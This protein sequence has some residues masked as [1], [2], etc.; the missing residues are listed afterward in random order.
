M[1]EKVDVV[2]VGAGFAGLG[3][4]YHLAASGL[5][6]L[7]VERG[8]YP[9]SKNVTGGRLYL[10]PV[11]PYFPDLFAEDGL[12]DI[13]FECLVVKERLTM[14]S[15]S[16]ATSIE[17]QPA[18]FGA[19]PAHSVTLLRG[20][21]DRWLGDVVAE[22]GA[23]VVPGYKVDDLVWED[24]RVVG[25]ISAGAEV[26]ADVVVAA[27]GAL[28]FIAERAGLRGRHDPRHFAVGIKEVIELPAERIRDRF[29]LAPGQ[30]ASQLFFG[31]L[32]LGMT[33]GGFLY[34]NRESLSLGLV[35]GMAAMEKKGGEFKAHEMM[36]SFK[37]RPEIAPLIAGGNVIEYSAHAVPEDSQRA[38]PRLVHNGLIV[39][40]DAAGLGLNMGLTVRGM[41]L[42][43]ASGA[44]AAQAILDARADGDFSAKSLAR[45]ESALRD[46]FVLQDLRTFE[47]MQEFLENPRL[48]ELYP[49][50]VSSLFEKLFWI[51]D[52]PKRSFWKTVMG[53]LKRLPKVAVLRDLWKAR[54]L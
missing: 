2:V 54:R 26:L 47:S 23:I 20:V 10:N 38:M 40:G 29:A 15:E 39:A 7:V 22:R 42:A 43:L 41:D 53:E 3:A 25:I 32:T 1:S 48:Y 30:G 44:M 13:P 12:A 18:S 4:A 34:T 36:D 45:Y 46:S 49:E 51:G 37:A 35:I 19:S 11:R 33:G 16:A 9:G 17:F 27:D 31:Q 6:V 8:D 5:E 24:E 28:S 52:G 14:M 21:F 50:A